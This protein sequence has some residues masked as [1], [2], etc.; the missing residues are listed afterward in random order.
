[1]Q[2]RDTLNPGVLL[3]FLICTLTF[4]GEL[5]AQNIKKI[6][7]IKAESMSYDKSRG[8][9]VNRVMGDVIFQHEGTLLYCDSAYMY[10]DDN[11]VDAMGL[12][13]IK[14]NDSTN[15]YGDSLRYDGNH[16]IAEMHK[17]V[18]MIDN[19][20]T[21]T[22]NHLNYNLLKKIGT[23]YDGGKI[24]DLENTLTSK[25]GTYY[26]ENKDFF[27]KDSVVLVNPDYIVRCDTLLYNTGSEISYFLGPTTITSKDNF[28][29]CER[30]W[31]NTKNDKSEFRKNAFM[32]NASHTL[33]GDSI[34]FDQKTGRGLAYKNVTI[35]DSVEHIILNGEFGRYEQKSQFS[36]VTDHA[37]MIQI[38]G[39]DSLFLHADTL[40]AIFDTTEQ[41]PK[42]MF[43]YNK[44]K[45]FRGTLQGMCDSLVYRF[46]DSTIRMYRDPILWSEEKQLTADTIVI[47]T[48][49]RAIKT[50][51]LYTNS[52]V[53]AV[54]DSTEK[55][56]N[57]V[58][59]V[60][61]TGYFEE[62]ELRTIY[63]YEK[64]ETIYF[65][66][67]DD[68]ARIGTNK[69]TGRNMIIHLKDNKISSITFLEKPAGTLFPDK[70]LGEKELFLKNFNWLV[71][72][73]PKTKADIFFWK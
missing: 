71:S 49:N 33:A 10:T 55:R 53:I 73:R 40:K 54:D 15:I 34:N 18:R 23:Y 24:V 68:V 9:N 1:M 25:K 66:R 35:T 42:I 37:Q 32:K 58:K 20:I 60:N 57:Q 36:V 47:Q 4:T 39:A 26:S 41:K 45:F 8:T 64:A 21:L 48:A 46:S 69:A 5:S 61:L 51:S 17:N 43:A 14:V 16:R 38:D 28:I 30:G 44:A 59:G 65:M 19:K 50:L 67:E 29:Y 7:L 2:R 62:N 72:L 52:F 31:Y 22:T 13:H 12:V 63:V 11:S 56:Y 70:E 27:F 3:L 6:D